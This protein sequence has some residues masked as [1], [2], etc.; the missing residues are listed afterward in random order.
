MKDDNQL[1]VKLLKQHIK[2][3]KIT[4]AE[5][6]NNIGLT[7]SGLHLA[8]KNNTL[9]VKDLL[10]I[11]EFLD[12][13]ASELLNEQNQYEDASDFSNYIGNEPDNKGRV[14]SLERELNDCQYH[15]HTLDNDIEKL[16]QKTER[17]N[18]K[19][20]WQEKEIALKDE[21]IKLLREKHNNT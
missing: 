14:E 19:I 16:N 7:E 5:V 8:L 4:Q 9:K 12:I 1:Y 6:A 20:E 15:N 10:K 11:A 17:L 3:N 13:E 21:I 2:D 18:Q